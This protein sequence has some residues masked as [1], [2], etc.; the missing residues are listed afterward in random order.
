[1]K[2]FINKSNK[3]NSS[4]IELI[5]EAISGKYGVYAK[6]IYGSNLSQK[7]LEQNGWELVKLNTDEANNLKSLERKRK[8]RIEKDHYNQKISERAKQVDICISGEP[9]MIENNEGEN[10]FVSLVVNLSNTH[11]IDAYHG[12]GK[13]TAYVNESGQLV[14]FHYGY[15]KP[16]NA[17]KLKSIQVSFSA[18]QI[19]I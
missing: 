12:C 4:S 17:P 14:A 6:G 16:S 11:M 15:D 5:K 3:R 1:M 18:T 19:C 10:P 7:K 2:F 8:A 9:L 13:G